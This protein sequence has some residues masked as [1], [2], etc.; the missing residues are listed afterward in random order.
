MSIEK[1]TSPTHKDVLKATRRQIVKEVQNKKIL[2]TK[3]QKKAAEEQKE[4]AVFLLAAI[5][6]T[7]A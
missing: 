6:S 4:R 7:Y 2:G 3:M 1:R 5:D